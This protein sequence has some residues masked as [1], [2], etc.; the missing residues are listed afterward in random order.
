MLK[1]YFRFF[2]RKLKRERLFFALNLSGLAVGLTA[3]LLIGLYIKD[4][5]SYDNFHSNKDNI[6]LVTSKR[7]DEVYASFPY[8][9]GKTLSNSIPGIEEVVSINKF[10]RLVYCKDQK[11]YSNE[12]IYATNNF[13]EVFDFNL[14]TGKKAVV[15]KKNGAV[16]TKDFA[17][18]LFGSVDEAVGKALTVN[19]DEQYI[20]SGVA[21]N[22]PPNSHLK[23]E[24]VLPAK[25]FFEKRIQDDGE[26]S[27]FPA[28]TY[29]LARG[30]AEKNELAGLIQKEGE[31]SMFEFYFRKDNQRQLQ[32]VNLKDIRLRSGILRM[33]E[34]VSDIRYVYLFT[35]IAFL[36]LLMACVN[37]VNL[38]TAQAI[39]RSKEVG[40]RKVIGASRGQLIRY[41]LTESFLTVFVAVLMAFAATERLLPLYNGMLG[42]GLKLEYFSFEFFLIISSI[43]LIVGLAAGLYPAFYLARFRPVH[44]LN[45]GGNFR[46]GG[47]LRKGL[48]IVQFFIAQLLVIA[49]LIIQ[50]QLLYIQQKDLG[51]NR[52]HLLLI[53]THRKLS[54]QNAGVFRQKLN[55]IAGVQEVSLSRN[56]LDYPSY[57]GYEDFEPEPGKDK[58]DIISVLFEVDHDFIRTMGVK[59]VAGRDFSSDIPTDMETA[60]ILNRALVNKLGWDNPIGKSYL[61]MGE[62][63]KVI[64][65]VEDFHHD[66]LKDQV[67][68]AV[69][70]LSKPHNYSFASVRLTPGNIQRAVNS[71]EKEWDTLVPGIP[72]DFQFYDDRYDNYYRAEMR[73]GGIFSFFSGLAIFISVVGVF[74]LSVYTIQQRIKEISIRKVLGATLIHLVM[75]VSRSYLW[76]LA[77]GFMLAAPIVYYFTQEWLANFQY[78]IQPGMGVFGLSAGSVMLLVLLVIGS[79]ALKASRANPADVLRNE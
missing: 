47:S 2:F 55:G 50:Q 38:A 74:G 24:V 6:Y 23:F 67:W 25:Q 15:L 39:K 10:E 40:L 30:G 29:L 79:Q 68:P 56:I 7:G 44:A 63:R 1:S 69:I 3:V 66:S 76:M 42:K 37:Y 70:V 41:F 11:S 57:H 36:I 17:I 22:V 20:I 64:G 65:V 28:K 26:R 48:I 8:R 19:G 12:C 78:R 72:M 73:L 54:E 4:E 59:L 14:L 49:T 9:V 27:Y 43:T 61:P 53:N 75:L 62:G 60:V 52:E 45:G 16:V 35:A 21:A 5:L 33:P 32:L 13:F 77:I 71:I 34:P 58:I 18:R 46:S 51:Y 31:R